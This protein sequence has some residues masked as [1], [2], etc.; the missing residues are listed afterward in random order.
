MT[1]EEHELRRAL[2]ARSGEPSPEFRARLSGVML[3]AR[4]TASATPVI[5]VVAAAA[6]TIATIGVL[7]IAR[8]GLLPVQSGPASASRV[9][10]PSPSPIAPPSPNAIALPTTAQLSAPSRDVVWAY[11]A[12]TA[13]YR[14]I[15]HGNTWEQRPLPVSQPGLWP[16]ISF[17][18]AQQGW[19]SESGSPETQCN[20]DGI[21]I[22]HTTDGAATWQQIA[23]VTSPPAGSSGISDSQCK[24][25]LSFIDAAHGFLAAWDDNHRPTIY[26]TSDGGRTWEGATLPDPPGFVTQTGGFSLRAGLVRAFGTTLLV[27]AFGTNAQTQQSVGY[28]FQSTDGGATW[29]YSENAPNPAGTPAFVSATRWLQLIGPDQSSETTDGGKSWHPYPSDYSQAAPI[30]PEVVFGD[31]LVGYAAVRGSIQRSVDGGLHWS[32]I[33]TPGT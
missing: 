25:G 14:S 13:L 15:D 24:E 17:V 31:P 6:L 26:R 30:A 16:E 22:W 9:T 21:V 20:A 29:R 11:V 8:H 7:L 19:Y 5:A 2:D 12:A 10:S 18:D 1:P 27:P 32:D 3:G 23:S 28:V 4:P 33:R